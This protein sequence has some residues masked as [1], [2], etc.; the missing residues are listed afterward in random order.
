MWFF[1]RTRGYKTKKKK[2]KWKKGT[3]PCHIFGV[4]SDAREPNAAHAECHHMAHNKLHI[5]ARFWR[6]AAEEEKEE[7]DEAS[8]DEEVAI[9]P[10]RF[11]L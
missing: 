7:E 9:S 6:R 5:C 4:S 1:G 11:F 10:S 8:D 3:N 2:S